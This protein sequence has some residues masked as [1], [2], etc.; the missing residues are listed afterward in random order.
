[1]KLVRSGHGVMLSASASSPV[2]L[3][4]APPTDKLKSIFAGSFHFPSEFISNSLYQFFFSRGL[5]PIFEPSLLQ[6]FSNFPEELATAL[7]KNT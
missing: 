7:V 1:M 2:P 5:F 6:N 3:L 4:S